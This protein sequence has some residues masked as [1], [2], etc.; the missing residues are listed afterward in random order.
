MP[1][2]GIERLGPAVLSSALT[3]PSFYSEVYRAAPVLLSAFMLLLLFRPYD[4]QP[5]RSL[6]CRLSCRAEKFALFT[7]PTYN[8]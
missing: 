2:N 5:G 3:T 8:R 6:D 7:A 1:R 4:G